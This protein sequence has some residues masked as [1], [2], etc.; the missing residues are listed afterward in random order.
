M[1]R[2]AIVTG[3]GRQWRSRPNR[4]GGGAGRRL[5]PASF[6]TRPPER[7]RPRHFAGGC[8]ALSS[9][10]MGRFPPFRPLRFAALLL[11]LLSFR[12]L[13]AQDALPP[14]PN[15]E[16]PVLPADQP[17]PQ[18]QASS[19]TS[20]ASDY[21]PRATRRHARRHRSYNRHRHRSVRPHRSRSHAARA[22]SVRKKDRTSSR[23]HAAD[24]KRMPN[25]ATKHSRHDRDRAKPTQTKAAHSDR[26]KSISGAAPAPDT[27]A[28]D[29]RR[30]AG[31]TASDRR[32][33]RGS[34]RQGKT[35]SSSHRG[36]G[37]KS[38]S[39]RTA[40]S[41]VVHD[42][43]KASG[44]RHGSRMEV[45]RKTSKAA[46]LSNSGDRKSGKAAEHGRKHSG[47]HDGRHRP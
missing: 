6:S 38:T 32:A 30:K 7:K 15:V 16:A 29:R 34:T 24:R 41:S 37:Q 4:C 47:T 35:D 39:S 12:P 3:P 43:K 21:R 5:R 25:S 27:K 28:G 9:A 17:P 31:T 11:A 26:K 40:R 18:R 1:G 44:K 20:A 45:T 23:R 13:A 10:V 46:T 14:P 42:S 33:T 8:G 22:S 2:G 19:P 36:R